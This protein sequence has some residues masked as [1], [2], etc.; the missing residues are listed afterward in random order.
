ME[1]LGGAQELHYDR[2]E[3]SCSGFFRSQSGRV[4]EKVQNFDCPVGKLQIEEATTAK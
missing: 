3:I 1:L 2:G 4:Y